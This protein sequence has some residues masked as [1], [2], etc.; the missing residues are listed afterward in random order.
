MYRKKLLI[1][2]FGFKNTSFQ[3]KQIAGKI[4]PALATTTAT[5]AGLVVLELYKIVE[6]NGQR[7]SV[8]IDRFKN[9]FINLALPFFA[10]SEPISAPIKTYKDVS[11]TI[12][13][14]LEIRGPKTLQEVMDFI[15]VSCHYLFYILYAQFLIKMELRIGNKLK[16]KCLFQY[17]KISF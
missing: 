16:S 11:F 7:A 1:H 8:P 17:L 12:W 13:D 14:S 6:K 9:A 15:K 2:F 10:F 3:T 5:V 4:I